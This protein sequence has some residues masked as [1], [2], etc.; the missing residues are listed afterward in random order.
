MAPRL[1]LD[2]RAIG[3]HIK[4]VKSQTDQQ[5]GDQLGGLSLAERGNRLRIRFGAM[6][7]KRKGQIRGAGLDKG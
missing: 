1:Q 3:S 5:Q 4:M 7:M 2:L 6:G